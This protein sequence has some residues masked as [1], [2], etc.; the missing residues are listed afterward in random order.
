MLCC[1]GG[2][3]ECV[4]W[5]CSASVVLGQTVFSKCACEENLNESRTTGADSILYTCIHAVNQVANHTKMLF[6]R[7]FRHANHGLRLCIDWITE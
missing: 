6:W 3:G 2:C 4:I 1:G 7:V 5:W